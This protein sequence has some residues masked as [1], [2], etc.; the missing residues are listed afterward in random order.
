MNIEDYR[1]YCLSLGDDVEEKLPFTAFKYA[2]GVLVFYVHGHM[3][4]FFD[5]DNFSVVTLKCQPER[6]EELKGQFQ[7]VVRPFN[8]SPKHWIGIDVKTAQ[9]D[10]LCE[11]TRNSYDIVKAKYKTCVKHVVQE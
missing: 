10:L 6:I 5:C 9:D 8:M 11:L 4:S 3:F 7:C 2:T 1:E